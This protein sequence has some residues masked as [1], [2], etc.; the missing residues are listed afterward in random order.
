M[1]GRIILFNRGAE[2]I[3]G[4]RAAEVVGR[5]HIEKLYG[6]RE[7]ARDLMRRLR[8]SGHGGVGRLTQ[9]RVRVRNRDGEEVPVAL[10]AA[11]I[12]EGERELATCGIFTDLRE[13]L[14]IEER[15]AQTQEKLLLTE[16]QA[17]VSE[18]S[19]AMAHEINQP[20]TSV[21]GYAELLRRTLPDDSRATGYVDTI[22]RETERMA[23]LVKKIGRLTKYETTR[24]VGEAQILDLERSTDDSK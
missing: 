14:Q 21:M 13:R 17:I 7:A 6:S 4:Y 9:T 15:L 8:D 2:R 23:E 10:S 12:Y 11:I 22:L 20:L 1:K 16:K 19:G 24:Y 18:I 5:M 3:M